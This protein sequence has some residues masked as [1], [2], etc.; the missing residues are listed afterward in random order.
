MAFNNI[1]AT[2]IPIFLF[3]LEW[4]RAA[5]SPTKGTRTTLKKT[6]KKLLR[7]AKDEEIQKSEA[8]DFGDWELH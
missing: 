1:Q 3:R 5:V 4:E 2:R 6:R 8:E 7:K